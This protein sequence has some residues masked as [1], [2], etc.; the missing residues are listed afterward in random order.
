MTRFLIVAAT[1]AA[2]VIAIGAVHAQTIGL[3]SP[4]EQQRACDFRKEVA[5][6][7]AALPEHASAEDYEAALQFTI[8][9][10]TCAPD[11][12][13]QMLATMSDAGKRNAQQVAFNNVLGRLT[14][15]TLERGTGAVARGFGTTWSAPVIYV[16]GGSSANYGV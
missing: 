2:G 5:T 7:F 10:S 14:R 4:V 16:G 6:E 11:E 15:R 9:Q 8:A 1:A 12:I 13:A 3:T